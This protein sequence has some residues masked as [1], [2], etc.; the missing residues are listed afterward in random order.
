VRHG[1]VSIAARMD[2]RRAKKAVEADL[3][4]HGAL[5]ALKR[6]H[7]AKFAVLLTGFHRPDPNA[8]PHGQR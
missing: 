3:A 8:P 4:P 5:S 1:Q 2:L 6:L 7:M